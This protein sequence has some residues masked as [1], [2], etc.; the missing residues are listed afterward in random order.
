MGESIK[1]KAISGGKWLTIHHI[2]RFTISFI[3][4]I[5]LARILEL[6]EFG[7]IGMITIFTSLADVLINS[8]LSI[9]LIRSKDTDDKDYST[10]FYFNL[11]VSTSLYLLLFF[12]A[13]SIAEFYQEPILIN[14]TRLICLV[15]LI[16]AWSI[17]Q[18]AIY[19]RKMD[20]KTQTICNLLGLF[21]SAIVAISM[22]FYGF[23]VYAI[24]GQA[25]TQA[26]VKT[27]AFWFYSNWRPRGGFYRSSFKKM[28]GFSSKV[29]ATSLVTRAA[30]EFDNVIIG[31]LF[32]PYQ[33]GLYT[34][35]KS[36]S[37]IPNGIIAGV[38]GAASFSVFSEVNNDKKELTRLHLRFFRVSLFLTIPIIGGLIASS[39]SFIVTLYSERWLEAVPMV[40]LVALTSIPFILAEFF[41]QTIMAVGDSKLYLKL[42]VYKKLLG[43]FA[44]PF[45]IYFGLYPFV[46]AVVCLKGVELLFDFIYV[47]RLLELK[48]GTY[49]K[50]LWRPLTIGAFMSAVV[51]VIGWVPIDI[52]IIVLGLQTLS[53][54][55]IYALL[56]YYFNREDLF[57]IWD[58]IKSKLGGRFKKNAITT[59]HEK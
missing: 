12:A 36:T 55:I 51:Y 28:W 14:I 4:S 42:N 40:Q 24:V 56:S 29:L 48:S 19:V 34:R 47:Q 23:G 22:A 37:Q 17:V 15:F 31:K 3:M 53:G 59:E 20:F 18:N 57:Y 26:L 2:G 32:N 38:L 13:P 16:N 52:P 46:I 54:V 45:G 6:E 30:D 25:I 10:V 7:I 50:N 58:I 41:T 43:L 11:A 9:A 49:L 21:A 8:G 27:V 1:N 5:F 44:I 33:L 35:G 39:E